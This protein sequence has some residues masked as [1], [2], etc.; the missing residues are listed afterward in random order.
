MKSIPSPNESKP[1]VMGALQASIQNRR[2]G[3]GQGFDRISGAN[4]VG[5]DR[6]NRDKMVKL[7]MMDLATRNL[8]RNGDNTAVDSV[9]NVMGLGT[10]A[11]TLR[12]LETLAGHKVDE[13][14]IKLFRNMTPEK[15]IKHGM[16]TAQ[17]DPNQNPSTRDAITHEDLILT[18]KRMNGLGMYLE[19]SGGQFPELKEMESLDRLNPEHTNKPLSAIESYVDGFALKEIALGNT[20]YFQ[21]LFAKAKIEYGHYIDQKKGAAGRRVGEPPPPPLMPPVYYKIMDNIRQ[22][23]AKG[24][25]G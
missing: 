2:V 4:G 22:H 14:T 25:E 8:K 5:R 19:K 21:K 6:I 20:P 9:G 13:L 12:N 3:N 11:W 24:G 7:L 23:A 17:Y 10:T 16:A 15:L 1:P 18:A